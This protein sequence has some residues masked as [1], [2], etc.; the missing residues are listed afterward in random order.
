VKKARASKTVK[1]K[2]EASIQE[3]DGRFFHA[4]MFAA[5]LIVFCA[6]FAGAYTYAFIGPNQPGGTGSGAIGVDSFDN[7]SVGSSTTRAN[8]KFLVVSSSTGANS[9]A[10]GIYQPDGTTPIFL[11]RDDK[12][13]AIGTSAGSAALTVG[14]AVSATSFDGPLL[15]GYVSAGGFAS[16]TGGGIFSFPNNLGV[17]TTTP[18]YKLDVFGNGRFTGNVALGTPIDSGDAATKNYVDTLAHWLAGGNYLYPASTGI[19]IAIGTS[20][21][22]AYRL[23]VAGSGRFTGTLVAAGG[24]NL[25]NGNITGVNKL[26]VTTIDPVYSIGGRDYATYVSDTIG[27]K[28]EVFGKVRLI[29]Q[30]PMSI[31][32]GSGYGY[33]IDFN[34]VA[35][36]SDLWLFWQTIKEGR[37]M[38]DVIILLTPEGS[39]A[40]VWY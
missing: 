14:G 17:G 20:T 21:A 12:K 2:K 10:F 16:Q 7:V 38:E 39:P 5:G 28:M 32:S 9:W 4:L 40:A 27:L 13:V 6:I 15:A 33:T 30:H 11:V 35:A 18:A 23:D 3:K 24:I 37:N 26:T 1:K 8:T 29:Y 34:K 19:N 31:E 36:G 25:N 22:P